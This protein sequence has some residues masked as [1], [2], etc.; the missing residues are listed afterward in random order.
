MKYLKL[1]SNDESYMA[2]KRNLGKLNVWVASTKSEKHV[3][4]SSKINN[5][6][7]F[8]STGDSTVAMTQKGT[9]NTTKNKMLQYKINNND[10]QNWD[11]SAV[12][13]SDGDK[14]YVKSD[15]EIPTAEVYMRNVICKYFIMTGSIAASGNIMSLVNFS[16]SVLNY[17]LSSLFRNCSS[18]TSA[19]ELPAT[20]LGTYCYSYM[21]MGCTSLTTAPELPATTLKE[22]CYS[23]MFNGCTSLIQAPELPATTLEKYC[24]A[25]MFEGCTSL[26]Q[27][28][29]LPATTLINYCYEYMFSGCTSLTQAPELPATTLSVYCYSNMFNGCTSLTQAPELP[30][31]TLVNRCY[32]SMFRGCT[33]LTQAPELPATTLTEYCYSGMFSECTS[34]TQ[35]PELPATT[36]TIHCYEYMFNGCTKLNHVK[37]LFTDKSAD[38]CLDSWLTNVS[39][40]GTFVKSKDAT[41]TN[42]N[43]GIP[44]GWKVTTV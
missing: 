2:D 10:W 14:M 24:Y 38:Y 30:A 33:S 44:S 43:A 37:A 12:S 4:Y 3:Y 17:G 11:L 20:T 28:P 8:T 34:L 29:E 40:T 9:P 36:L 42:G 6:L 19:P 31:T 22:S 1:Y 39:T 27:A 26:T 13:L 41:W 21:F 25:D 18:L 7:C 32:Y 16:D 5:Y 35:A 23:N 15:D